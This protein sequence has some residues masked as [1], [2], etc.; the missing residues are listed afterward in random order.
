MIVTMGD[1]VTWG[2]GLLDIHKFD[3]LFAA[4]RE[5]TR[6][7]HSGA[8]IGAQTDNSTEKVYPEVPVAHPSVWQQVL[9]FQDWAD[10]D[11]VILNGGI[12]DVSLTR[13]LNPLV[14]ATQITQLTTQFCQEGMK[15]LLETAVGKLVKPEA[16]IA[17]VGYYPILSG[18]SFFENENQP[19]MLMELH[20]VA[21]S[22]VALGT[23][24]SVEGLIPAIEANCLAF[25]K[26]SDTALQA[27][28]D[29][30]NE[31]ARRDACVFVQAPFTEENS[32]WA[33]HPLLWELSPLLDAEDEAEIKTLRDRACTELY[34]DVVDAL[35]WAKCDRA[36]VGHPNVEGAAKI[37]AALTA[38]V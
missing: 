4:G 32:M 8:T 10:V 16:K 3:R 29:A 28:V 19:R 38:A 11:V 14:P 2:Q 18:E 35:Q 13:I 21:T 15:A 24:F 7:A 25:W 37:A 20:G 1:S 31:N 22:S 6:I 33:K 34:G 17:V 23:T 12:N 30:A 26:T 9:G 36:S 27:A 5:L